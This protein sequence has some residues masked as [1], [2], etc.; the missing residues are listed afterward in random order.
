MIKQW[1]NW[2]CVVFTILEVREFKNVR[3]NNQSP[4][5][6]LSNSNSWG[7]GQGSN[8]SVLTSMYYTENLKVNICIF[9]ALFSNILEIILYLRVNIP[10]IF[11]MGSNVCCNNNNNN[12]QLV[13]RHMSM[14]SCKGL[15]GHIP[16][17]T[18]LKITTVLFLCQI[19]FK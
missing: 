5:Q 11:L 13:T 8:L 15:R 4:W 6:R 9:L 10:V 12:T 3:I 19:K 1:R 7:W 14:T 16:L 2:R 18:T 17:K